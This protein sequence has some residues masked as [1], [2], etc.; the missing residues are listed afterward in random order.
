MIEEDLIT[1]GE[2]EPRDNFET[3]LTERMGIVRHRYFSSQEVQVV[4][5][6]GE[7]KK[8]WAGTRVRPVPR[9]H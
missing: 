2:L 1:L 8:C 4:F 9:I 6:D 3:T 5:A 7:I